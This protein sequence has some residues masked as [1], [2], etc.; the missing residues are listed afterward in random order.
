M[1][2]SQRVKEGTG[3]ICEGITKYNKTRCGGIV[4]VKRADNEY[5]ITTQHTQKKYKSKQKGARISAYYKEQLT[6]NR[7]WDTRRY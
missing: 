1:K 7:E 6:D 2:T 5:K 4:R 3:K